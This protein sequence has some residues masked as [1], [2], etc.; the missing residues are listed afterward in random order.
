MYAPCR[1]S[2]QPA[3]RQVLDELRARV[4][5]L[6]RS[7]P[8]PSPDPSQRSVPPAS[9]IPAAALRPSQG[10]RGAA[11]DSRGVGHWDSR[12]FSV[13]WRPP[14]EGVEVLQARF[15]QH[16]YPR[17][18]H[19]SATIA[20][21]DAGTA[22]FRYR[23]EDFV[24]GPGDVFLINPDG[25]HTGRAIGTEGYQYRVLYLDAD[26]LRP[27]LAADYDGRTSLS[28]R[29]TILREPTIAALLRRTHDAMAVPESQ[30]Q[31]Q[32]LLL[33]LSW[34]LMQ[35]YGDACPA[36]PVTGGG[37]RGVAAAREYLEAHPAEKILLRDLATVALSSPHRL[38]R[39]FS[40]ELGMPPHAYQK[41]LRVRLARRLLAEGMP[42]V[43][44]AAQSGFYDQ[45][46]FSR[47]FKSY[48]G[49]TP[50]QFSLGARSARPA[51]SPAASPAE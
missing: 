20:L 50:S 30:L 47:V 43:A 41:Q 51:A 29:Q 17:H 24:V 11:L 45:A 49:V 34:L 40:A 23:G 9:P 28:F 39:M 2:L 15:I 13:L 8:R 48:T 14:I 4:M 32:E 37:G 31:S 12:E 42:P 36:A 18:A 35:R 21:M 5:R 3:H 10:R 7:S 1:T 44:V 27:L 26:V 6:R 16:Q 25:V 19:E 22:S 46:H 33:R 38:V